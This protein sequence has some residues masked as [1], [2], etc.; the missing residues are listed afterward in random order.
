MNTCVTCG[1]T[2]EASDDTVALDTKPL[3]LI[4][5]ALEKYAVVEI[6]DGDLVLWVRSSDV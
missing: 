3:K 1:R 5:A 2:V 4:A 6:T